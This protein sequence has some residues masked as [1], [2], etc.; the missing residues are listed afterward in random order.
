MCGRKTQ[1]D[2]SNSSQF[3]NPII[4]MCTVYLS[5]FH[6]LQPP[7][8]KSFPAWNTQPTADERLVSTARIRHSLLVNHCHLLTIHSHSHQAMFFSLGPVRNLR[9]SSRLNERNKKHIMFVY[10]ASPYNSSRFFISHPRFSG[11]FQGSPAYRLFLLDRASIS[12]A[13]PPA[14]DPFQGTQCAHLISL[15]NSII[16]IPT[17][18]IA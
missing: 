9:L 16:S 2:D 15:Q 11:K 3:G 8:R 13:T 4:L 1:I 18:P 14:S 12:R 17:F 7:S 5:G 10:P 6:H